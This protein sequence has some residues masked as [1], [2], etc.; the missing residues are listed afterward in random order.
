MMA[1]PVKMSSKTRFMRFPTDRNQV[2]VDKGIWRAL[3]LLT[4]DAK[5]KKG[6]KL[7]TTEQRCQIAYRKK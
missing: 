2:N 1:R 4:K 5:R 7:R 3:R 6:G